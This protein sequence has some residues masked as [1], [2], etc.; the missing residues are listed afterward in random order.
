M[1]RESL[2]P[3]KQELLDLADK[4]PGSWLA[5]LARDLVYN[6]EKH[7]GVDPQYRPRGYTEGPKKD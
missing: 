6:G 4:N 7:S 2:E 1:G 5:F 3:H